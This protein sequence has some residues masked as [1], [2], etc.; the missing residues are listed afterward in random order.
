MERLRVIRHSELSLKRLTFQNGAL[1]LLGVWSIVVV[2]AVFHRYLQVPLGPIDDHE[3]PYYRTLNPSSNWLTAFGDGYVRASQEFV[4]QAR[5]RPLY[6]LGRTFSVTIVDQAALPR[7]L[8]RL[9]VL[10]STLF[11]VGGIITRISIRLG[12]QKLASL[13]LGMSSTLPYAALLPWTDVVGRLGPPDSFAWLG[14][15][16]FI[17]FIFL[18]LDQNRIYP[19]ILWIAVFLLAGFR[20]NYAVI[21]PILMISPF[22]LSS[23]RPLR[24]LPAL[25]IPF[26]MS[27]VGAAMVCVTL[28]LRGG[29]DYYGN[30]RGLSSFGNGLIVMLSSSYFAAFSLAG[31]ISM[32]FTPRHFRPAIARVGLLA[33]SVVF[34]DFVVYEETIFV[35]P[36][37]GLV[38]KFIGVTAWTY[39]A[40]VI[41]WWLAGYSRLG[42]L[43]PIQLTH[44]LQVFCSVFLLAVV[45]ASVASPLARQ[46]QL[47]SV[48]QRSAQGFQVLLADI[49]TEVVLGHDVVI[50]V[51]SDSSSYVEAD[52]SERSVSLQR[53]LVHAFADGPH[54]ELYDI[55]RALGTVIMPNGEEPRNCILL[56][57]SG[58]LISPETCV[59]T[60]YLY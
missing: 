37:Y 23:L 50:F 59:S 11:L 7:Y 3:Y 40:L 28:L 13:L 51:D 41:F 36:R 60:V 47:S 14:I 32:L 55:A 20:E 46:Q 22:A 15:V 54:V 53:F 38:S 9:L 45:G 18:Y 56:G 10:S 27:V 26:L 52:L 57:V 25:W 33:M 1:F 24:K 44:S 34:I 49:Q 2:L 6:H 29:T 5:F 4:N 19:S 8:I 31:L 39:A 21:A 42:R 16:F 43:K 17:A 12:A 48:Q 30:T 35:Y 58:E